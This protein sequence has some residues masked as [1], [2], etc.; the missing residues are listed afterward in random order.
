MCGAILLLSLGIASPQSL[1]AE[2]LYTCG[3]HPQIIKKEP[4]NCP[5]CG[6]ALVPVRSNAAST[7]A[8]GGHKIKFY[9]SSMNPGEVSNQPGKDSMGMDLT[10]VYEE[11]DHSAQTI[12]IDAATV[13]RMNLKTGL[14]TRG[15]VIRELRTVGAVAYNENGLRDI[16]TKYE[17]WIE[18][19]F[20]S[21]TWTAVKAGD[22]L[23]EIYSPDL[24]NAELN[25]LVALRAEGGGR[26]PAHPGGAGASPALRHSG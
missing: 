16:T 12:R 4:G 24:Y 14:V 13:Q 9:K 18:K 25:Y 21:A 23:F 3:M 19:L 7:T 2:Q 22:Q 8:S 5:I 10:P 20:V 17:G 6:M 11:S 1:A 15:P 26:E